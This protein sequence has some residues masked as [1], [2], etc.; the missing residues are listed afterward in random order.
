MKPKR[1]ELL[2][3]SYSILSK[4]EKDELEENKFNSFITEKLGKNQDNILRPDKWEDIQ[5]ITA[6]WE[7]KKPVLKR[8][9]DPVRRQEREKL[10]EA[11][12]AEGLKREKSSR[13]E[14]ENLKRKLQE[15]EENLEKEVKLRKQA[16]EGEQKFKGFIEYQIERDENIQKRK[17]QEERDKWFKDELAKQERTR[18]ANEKHDKLRKEKEEEEKEKEKREKNEFINFIMDHSKV[19]NHSGSPTNPTE[20]SLLR[21]SKLKEEM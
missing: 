11:V 10:K 9:R 2:T 15:V 14:I 7:D 6:E 12:I 18:I 20:D 13:K 1:F 8:F 3:K 17:E 16:Q 21:R 5:E 19:T 4:K